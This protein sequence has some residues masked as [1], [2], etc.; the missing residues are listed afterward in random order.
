[1]TRKMMVMTE[2]AKIKRSELVEFNPERHRLT[3]A[4]LEYGIEEAKRIK[5]WPAL[6]EAVDLKIEEQRK[7]VAWW[8][9]SVSTGHGG[10]RQVPSTRHL[11]FRDAEDIT[12]MKHQRV[13]DLGKKL[14]QPGDKYRLHLLG[15]GYRAAMLE[16]VHNHRAQGTGENEWYTPAKYIGLARRVLGAIDLDPASSDKAQETVQATKYFT[17]EQNGLNQ[18]WHGRVWLNPPYAQPLIAHFADKIVTERTAGRVTEAI[19]LTH[20]YT[21]TGWFHKAASVADAICF[22][23]G[24]IRFIDADS[25]EGGSTTQGQAFFYYGDDGDKFVSIFR[26]IGLV[27][28]PCR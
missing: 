17:A 22:T 6:E 28:T 3:V 1:M 4:A 19:M 9:A 7:F 15:A 27:V 2:I 14:Q 20:N 13:S 10:D 23:R 25:N 18:E 12:G 26:E 5:D 11:S 24:R 16:A 8:K 21:D